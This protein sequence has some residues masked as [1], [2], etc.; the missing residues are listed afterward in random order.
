MNP[1]LLRLENT[2]LLVS[3]WWL[4]FSYGAANP[5]AFPKQIN[6]ALMSSYKMPGERI[7]LQLM[8]CTL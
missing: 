2:A 8:A 6:T 5:T 7:N 3:F 4:L 1:L